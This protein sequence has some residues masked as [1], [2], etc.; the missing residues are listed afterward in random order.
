MQRPNQRSVATRSY[1]AVTNHQERNENL[2]T[3]R[4]PEYYT[5]PTAT[6]PGEPRYR[7]KQTGQKILRRS[8]GDETVDLTANDSDTSSNTKARRGKLNNSN[9]QVELSRNQN[10]A[11]STPR[12]KQASFLERMRH[13]PQIAVEVQGN[14][15]NNSTMQTNQTGTGAN[16]ASSHDVIGE[17]PRMS[18]NKAIENAESLSQLERIRHHVKMLLEKVE[19]KINRALVKKAL[20]EYGKSDEQ[21]G[22]SR[23]DD[24]RRDVCCPLCFSFNEVSG[25]SPTIMMQ[26]CPSCER[27]DVCQSCRSGCGDC[28]RSCCIDCI[29]QCEACHCQLCPDC[30]CGGA[31]NVNAEENASRRELCRRCAS[32]AA[33]ESVNVCDAKKKRK[34]PDARIDNGSSNTSSRPNKKRTKSSAA[35]SRNGIN[36]A[37]KEPSATN[38]RDDQSSLAKS[39]NTISKKLTTQPAAAL[40][41]NN[42]SSKKP[43]LANFRDDQSSL[44]VESGNAIS[45]KFT[46]KPAAA[47]P[48]SNEKGGSSEPAV[49]NSDDRKAQNCYFVKHLFTVLDKVRN[50]EFL[51][52]TCYY[53]V[54]RNW[55]IRGHSV[56]L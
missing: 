21:G 54:S 56:L 49:G 5:P 47:L 9:I 50:S 32:S 13:Q 38:V 55:L 26:P 33:N 30:K 36:G 48:K 41:K 4:L 42:G 2:S 40:P 37:R 23:D 43:N 31:D 35:S 18:L 45:T 12:G 15:N 52:S 11:H 27:P 29:L 7:T 1:E 44:A 51:S 39:G 3:H 10:G 20:D 24:M 46:T 16:Q 25:P 17:R 14:Q 19:G 22:S 6:S 34:N 53:L 8:N 28:N